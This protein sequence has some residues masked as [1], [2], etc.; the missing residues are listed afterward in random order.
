MLLKHCSTLFVWMASNIFL[1]S[2]HFFVPPVLHHP[3]LFSLLCL[4]VLLLAPTPSL[5]PPLPPKDRRVGWDEAQHSGAGLLLP[6]P[7]CQHLGHLTPK[8][9]KEEVNCPSV[10]TQGQVT[11]EVCSGG[12]QT[13]R[14][15]EGCTD[16]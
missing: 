2:F 13:A 16:S 14:S 12:R 15:K 6:R 5:L 3:Y 9:A 11:G 1:T 4:L 7:S 8:V 10:H